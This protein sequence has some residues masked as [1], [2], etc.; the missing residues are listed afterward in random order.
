[1]MFRIVWELLVHLFADPR[2]YPSLSRLWPGS[3]Y[4]THIPGIDGDFVP[5]KGIFRKRGGF[6]DSSLSSE[7]YDKLAVAEKLHYSKCLRGKSATR[8]VCEFLEQSTRGI[9]Q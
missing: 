7:H 4:Q 8:L 2:L 6:L 3:F 5:S 1:M 9:E